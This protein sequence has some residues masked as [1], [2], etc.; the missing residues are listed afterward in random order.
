MKSGL[1]DLEQRFGKIQQVKDGIDKLKTELDFMDA[2]K[3]KP[4]EFWEKRAKEVEKY[5]DD[6]GGP[7]EDHP[8]Q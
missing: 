8:I 7:M 6:I 1:N 3:D 4:D 5:I 2:H